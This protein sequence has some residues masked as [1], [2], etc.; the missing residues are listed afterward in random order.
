MPRKTSRPTDP[1][2][3]MDALMAYEPEPTGPEWFTVQ[4]FVQ[5]YKMV[6][7]TGHAR[8]LDME[9]R[10]T[11]EKWIGHREGCRG[12]HVTKWRLKK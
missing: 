11:V 10:G 7:R 1:W 8:L 5:R 12:G 3:A 6:H 9:R 4:E 2:A